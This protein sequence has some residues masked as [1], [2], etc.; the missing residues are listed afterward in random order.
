M[1]RAHGV[2]VVGAY[3]CYLVVTGGLHVLAATGSWAIWGAPL[4]RSSTFPAVARMAAVLGQPT[5]RPPLP[6]DGRP[7][8]IASLLGGV[9]DA[10]GDGAALPPVHAGLA[11]GFFVFLLVAGPAAV[12]LYAVLLRVARDGTATVRDA[13]TGLRRFGAALRTFLGAASLQAVGV[14]LLIV[15]GVVATTAHLPALFLVADGTPRARTALRRAWALTS[16]HRWTVLG[17]Y[18]ALLLLG[19]M[20]GLVVL[21]GPRLL[22]PLSVPLSVVG[23]VLACGAGVLLGAY[24][25]CVV[26]QFY[27]ALRRSC[28]SR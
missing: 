9:L 7:D 12:G 10:L 5:W 19:S 24:G 11:G 15:P 28:S 3:L 23:G 13:I 18:V 20:P 25:L 21:V 22:G 17:A 27:E 2:R 16:G 14:L 6:A 1:F 4:F 8:Q 26:T